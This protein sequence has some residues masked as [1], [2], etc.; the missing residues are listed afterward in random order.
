MCSDRLLPCVV[1]FHFDIHNAFKTCLDNSPEG[2]RTRVRI[3][4]TWL[5]YFRERHPDKWPDIQK[6]L[7]KNYQPEQFAVE[8]FMFVQGRTDSSRKWGELVETFIFSELGLL[9]NWSD[10]CTYSRIYKHQPVI[11]CHATDDF[12]LIC[13]ERSTYDHIVAVQSQMDCPCP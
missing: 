11:L 7:D 1:Y 9:P 13:K 12:R 4:Q 6:L 10:L 5:D 8:M 2:E 3:N